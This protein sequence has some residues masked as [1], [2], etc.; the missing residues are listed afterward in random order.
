[1]TLGRHRRVAG[2]DRVRRDPDAHRVRRA[3]ASGCRR[4]PPPG[5][6]S[7][8]RYFRVQQNTIEQLV[9]FLPSLY[10]FAAFVSENVAAA[11]GIVFILGRVG[12][13]ARL[14]R[15]PGEAR[16]G[17]H[18]HLRS[19]PDPPARRSDRSDPWPALLTPRLTR[20]E[21]LISG[22][23]AAGYALAARP[24]RA[25]AIVTSDEGLVAGSVRV[26]A[27]DVEIGA[28]RAHPA[29]G[30]P[31]PVVLVVHEIFGV[32][33]YIAD[34]VRRLA[35]ARLLRDRPGSL[36]APGRSDAAGERRSDPL[37]RGRQGA[38]RAGDGRPRR[39]ARL[40]GSRRPWR[41]LARC[42]HRLLLGRADR[43][44]LL[45]PRP[46]AALRCRLVRAPGRRAARADAEA[47]DRRRRTRERAGARSLRLR[48]PEHPA[49]DACSRCG[50]S[51]RPASRAR[52]SWCSRPRRTASTPTTAT[53][54]G[55]WP[56]PRAGSA[57]WPGSASTEW[58]ER[59]RGPRR[60]RAPRTTAAICDLNHGKHRQQNRHVTPGAERLYSC[61]HFD[62][63]GASGPGTRVAAA[64]RAE[65]NSTKEAR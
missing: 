32:H 56:P 7:F 55:R 43:L 61:P 60:R 39:D 22:A 20:R 40:R 38:R 14:H 49:G 33:A 1:M 59:R 21:V 30:G 63:S 65:W 5:N 25:D 62:P 4:P 10:L 54:T 57:C 13:R 50:R 35:K 17:L 58:P 51:W 45:R 28:Y 29:T 48:R 2:S 46:E 42:D 41:R 26:P 31:F 8:E 34:V 44:A 11:L 24:V 64:V 16:A 23:V 12:L 53:A 19:Q 9:I 6:P 15:G 3:G 37:E 36:P 52:R 18:A 47:P 27:G